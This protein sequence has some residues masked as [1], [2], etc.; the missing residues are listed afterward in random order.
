MDRAWCVRL[1]LLGG[2]LLAKGTSNRS[3]FQRTDEN[4]RPSREVFV[5]GTV[6][7]KIAKVAGQDL[8]PKDEMA[9]HDT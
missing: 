5:V 4:L 8:G 1:A 3:N 9:H 2:Q 6:P 7:G